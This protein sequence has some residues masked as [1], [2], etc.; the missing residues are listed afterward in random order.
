MKEIDIQKLIDID[1]AT[2]TRVSRRKGAGGSQEFFTP[3]SIVKRMC[4]KISEEDWSDPSKTFLEPCMGSGNFILMIIYNR[5]IH[6]I[7]W[8][9]AIE[10]LYGVELMQDNVQEC[11]DRVITLLKEM[12]IAFSEQTAIDIMNHNF[13]CHDFFTWNFEE[14]REYTEEELK[15]LKKKK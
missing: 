9:T 14:W 3:Y 12:N 10:T 7:D 8:Q 13:V 4:D 6:G 11:K 15:E 1:Y 2:N 5:I